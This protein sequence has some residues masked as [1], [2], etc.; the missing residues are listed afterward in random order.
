M[1][2]RLKMSPVEIS[3]KAVDA[4]NKFFKLV[5]AKFRFGGE[6]VPSHDSRLG[7]QGKVHIAF[8]GLFNFKMFQ[9]YLA[10]CL[11]D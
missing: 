4:P 3:S 6:L 2:F 10:R 1:N 5:V 11:E 8:C 9:S 7:F